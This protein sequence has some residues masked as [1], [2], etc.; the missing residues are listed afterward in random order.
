[1]S[2]VLVVD[3]DEDIRMLVAELLRVS[4]HEVVG[5]PSGVEALALLEA[6]ARPDLVLLDVQ[7]PEL[8]G[9]DTLRGIRGMA[10]IGE[11]PVVLCTVKSGPVDTALG[12]A[13]GCDGYVVKPF[14]IVDLVE[15]V[16][17]V[18]SRTPEE[19]RTRRTLPLRA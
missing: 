7:M 15:E 9:W 18:L 11:V 1:M 12:Q 2:K 4:G 19:R 8:D 16:E 6:G 3:D 5:A 14:A 13:L 10:G 17:A